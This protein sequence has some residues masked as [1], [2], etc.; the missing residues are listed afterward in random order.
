[1]KTC[2]KRF[3][4]TLIGFYMCELTNKQLVRFPPPLWAEAGLNEQTLILRLI[5]KFFLYKDEGFLMRLKYTILIIG[6][7]YLKAFGRSVK[8]TNGSIHRGNVDGCLN[9]H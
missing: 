3:Y 6:T 1:M 8:K 7:F 9:L 4:Y 5:L 2:A